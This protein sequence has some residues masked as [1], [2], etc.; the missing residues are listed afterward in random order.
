MR[1]AI[2]PALALAIS[3]CET[4]P[5]APTEDSD[6]RFIT[7]GATGYPFSPAVEADGWIFLSGALGV[8]PEGQLIE[9][10]IEA[11]TRQTMDNIQ[12]TLAGVGLGM[13]RVVKCTVFLAD[14]AE[15]PAFNAVYKTYF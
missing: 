3:A 2:L 5:A 15:W 9:G 12:S 14:I 4:L 1:L 13:D 7:A 8:T 6:I 11:E 10:G